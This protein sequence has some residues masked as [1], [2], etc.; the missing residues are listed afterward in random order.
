MSDARLQAL[1][2]RR[3]FGIKPGLEA[4]AAVWDA[5]GRPTAGL[6]ALHVVGTNGKGSV[7]AMAAHA[8]ARRGHAVGLYTSP[9]LQRVTERVRLRGEEVATDLLAAAVDRVLAVERTLTTPARALSFFEVLTLAALDVLDGAGLDAIVVEAGLGG[10]LDATRIVDARAVVV[11]SI[12]RDHERWLGDTL[13]AIAAEKAGVFRADVPVFT[14][15]Q[16]PEAMAVLREHAERVGCPL[17][18][19]APLPS[20]PLPGAYQRQNAAL[21]L[22]AARVL[23]PAIDGAD[24][25]GVRWPGRLECRRVAGE[26]ELVLDVAHNP[27]AVAAIVAELRTWVA[28]PTVVLFACAPDKDRAPM[29]ASLRS[30]GELWTLADADAELVAAEGAVRRFAGL[31]DP[32][33]AAAMEEHLAS[34]GR[35]VVCGSHRLVGGVHGAVVDPSDPR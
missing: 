13:G 7:A 18:V 12:A 26:G 16:D 23:D 2:G 27:A 24:L 1:F 17:H 30:L 15:D 19:C 22:A 9:H 14:C 34:G 29:I 6:P 21:A 33:L 20:A 28:R 25:D 11:T 31:R 8:L 10:R 35:L 4:I 3:T 5:L 32:D